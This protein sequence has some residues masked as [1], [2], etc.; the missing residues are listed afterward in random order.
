MFRFVGPPIEIEPLKRKNI[1][2]KRHYMV[3]DMVYP[4]VTT[5]TGNIPGKQE[6]LAK[7]RKRV[8]EKEANKI[9]SS[10]ARR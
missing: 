9:S 6:G 3:D 8:G 10:A 4:S 2:G 5:I 7:W 1:N